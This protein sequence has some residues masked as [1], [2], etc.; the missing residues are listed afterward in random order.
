MVIMT[1]WSIDVFPLVLLTL[2]LAAADIDTSR[3][4][5]EAAMQTLP[6]VL[7][8]RP[9]ANLSLLAAPNLQRGG[10]VLPWLD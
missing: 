5:T 6:T 1:L 7:R 3:L 4:T 10:Q 2:I 9:M 8:C